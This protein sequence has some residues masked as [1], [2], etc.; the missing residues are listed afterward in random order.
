MAGVVLVTGVSRQL[1]ARAAAA[2]KADPGVVRVIGVDS[3]DAAPTAETDAGGAR[4]AEIIA[5]AGVDTVVHL[6]QVHASDDPSGRLAMHETNVIGAMRLLAACQRSETVS[7]IVIGSST[8]VY[9][10]TPG[11]PAVFTE[12]IAP[13]AR[14]GGLFA[15]DLAGV[16]RYARDLRERR[17]DIAIS[18]LRLAEILGPGISTPLTRYLEPAL[19]PVLLGHD[20]RLQFLYADDA[21]EAVRRM[22]VADHPGVFNVAGHG[23]LTLSQALRRSGRA[24][25]R[26]PRPG[27]R[28][29]G[30]LAARAGLRRPPSD[31]LAVLRHGRVVDTTAIER[32]LRWSPRFTTAEAFDAHFP[33]LARRPAT[34]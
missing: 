7:R 14:P 27:M 26:V 28:A 1:G 24:M 11:D 30:G 12:R 5:D 3:V 8:E 31:E 18:V 15:R 23:T 17:G 10:A 32:E 20:P 16:E 6:D 21:V 2:L 9:G 19:V 29:F 22:A 4:Y 13:R 25:L 33:R 34:A